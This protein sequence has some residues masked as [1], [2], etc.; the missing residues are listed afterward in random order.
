MQDDLIHK[1]A[2]TAAEKE[3]PDGSSY[4]S[5]SFRNQ[6]IL[7]EMLGQGHK[8]V[9]LAALQQEIVP[10]VYAR[11]RRPSS[12]RPSSAVRSGQRVAPGVTLLP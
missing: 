5:L 2:D 9:Q 12:S 11:N 4:L 10:E 3:R 8:S 7:A 6:R 1:V